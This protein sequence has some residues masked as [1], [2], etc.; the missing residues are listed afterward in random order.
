MTPDAIQ[1][2]F[3]WLGREHGFI[4]GSGD[5]FKQSEEVVAVLDLER[6]ERDR[7]YYITVGFALNQLHGGAGG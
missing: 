5:L 4:R 1:R 2:A 3:D 7:S 6:S